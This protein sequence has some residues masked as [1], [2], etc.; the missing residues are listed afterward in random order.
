MTA[1]MRLDVKQ[2]LLSQPQFCLAAGIDMITA[3]NW[4]ARHVLLPSEIGGRQI[5]GTRLYS[6]TKAFEGKLIGE[7]VTF[8]KIPPSEAAKVAEKVVGAGWVGHWTKAFLRGG[9]YIQSFMVVAW[10]GGR[11][12]YQ[13]ISGDPAT[14]RPDFSSVKAED[15]DYFL[16]HPF[17]VL[18]L[19]QLY[20]EV[21]NKC[22]AILYGS[23]TDQKKITSEDA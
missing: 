1:K 18:P 3:N 20:L 19:S 22:S 4:V 23:N 13:Q 8:H 15:V 21:F 6:V 17:I 9:P 5:K 14:G 2:P 7:L 10:I 12:A 11:L 16:E